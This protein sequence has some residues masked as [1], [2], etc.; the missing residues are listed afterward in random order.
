MG[1]RIKIGM[2][3]KAEKEK[4]SGKTYKQIA[5]MLKKKVL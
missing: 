5:S 4:Y 3:P 2:I 1:Y